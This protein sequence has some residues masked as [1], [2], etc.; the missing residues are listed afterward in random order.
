MKQI[1]ATVLGAVTAD[2]AEVA[3][4]SGISSLTRFANNYIHQNVEESDTSVQVRAVIGKKVGVAASDVVTPEGLKA[5][6]ERAVTLARLQ[7]DNPDFESLP[8]PGPIEKVDAFNEK[9]AAFSPE[10]RA[11]VVGQI[12]DAARGARLY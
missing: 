6:A 1:A 8:G 5:V 4:Y 9:T 10:Q 12:C 3:V 11:A 2:Q 7:A